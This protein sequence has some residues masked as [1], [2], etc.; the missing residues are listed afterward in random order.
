MGNETIFYY[1]TEEAVTGYKRNVKTHFWQKIKLSSFV[2]E[3]K[4]MSIVAV[5]IPTLQKGWKKEK[6]LRLMQE[7]ITEYPDVF[8]KTE[9][10]LQPE[11][12]QMLMQ[13]DEFPS[14][15]WPLSEKI[16]HEKLNVEMHSMAKHSRSM[17][18]RS[19]GQYGVVQLSTDQRSAVQLNTE[20][21][22]AENSMIENHFPPRKK[23]HLESV[24]L[25]LG[26]TFFPEEQMQRFSDMMQPYFSY[27]NQLTILYEVDDDTE[28]EANT[29]MDA[30]SDGWQE[31]SRWEEI[32]ED[33]A[34]EFYYEYGLV[35][36]VRRGRDFRP[37]RQNGGNMQN[38]MIFLD[39]GYAGPLPL[40]AM[41]AGGIYLDVI[42][43][44]RKETLIRQKCAE[45]SYLSPRKYLD[46]VVKSGYDKLVNPV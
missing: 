28:P 31:Q 9:I 40:R 29:E 21:H 13:P 27:I 8:G 3:E 11:I 38:P 35:S 30:E 19:T 39:Y 7:V 16:L 33:Y 1:V 37:E 12:Q 17:A 23:S 46:T 25:M 41:R 44:G 18:K 22:S 10:I 42:S 34:E 24:V 32:L 14:V 4:E 2:I 43:S 6:L 15:F 45:I 26:D 5:M 20:Q 36:E